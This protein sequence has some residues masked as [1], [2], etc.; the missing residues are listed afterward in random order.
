MRN[1]N[2]KLVILSLIKQFGR[3][4]SWRRYFFDLFSLDLFWG[5]AKADKRVSQT[6]LGE[7][8]HR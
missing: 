2:A 7:L 4:V 3:S 5:L 1:F 6:G 8:A